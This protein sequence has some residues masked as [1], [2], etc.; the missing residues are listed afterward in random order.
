MTAK[1]SGRAAA[2]GHGV[3]LLR[4]LGGVLLVAV[5]L[6]SVAHA[7]PTLVGAERSYVVT[8]GSM[9]PVLAPGDVIYVYDVS[10]GAVEEGDV[11]TFVSGSEAGQT[12]VTTHR[13]VEIRDEGGLRFVT[14]GDANEEPDPSPILPADIVGRV[15]HVLGVPVHVPALGK[16]LLFA[17]S[18]NGVIAL[19]FLP[20]GLLILNELWLLAGEFGVTPELTGDGEGSDDATGSGTTP[21]SASD[22][23]PEPEPGAKTGTDGEPTV[24]E[25]DGESGAD[26]PAGDDGRDGRG[27]P[28]NGASPGAAERP[29]S[30]AGS[31]ADTHNGSTPADGSGD[32]SD[33]PAGATGEGE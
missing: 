24:P 23:E 6:V 29:E 2:I 12:Q 17:G 25:P 7:V 15:P 8:S 1:P 19:V 10:P 26:E 30:D 13:V 16:L 21:E 20:V 11:I 22:S 33:T 4:V 5:V 3:R 32:P 27:D 28:G 31:R 9:T 14:Q 18:R